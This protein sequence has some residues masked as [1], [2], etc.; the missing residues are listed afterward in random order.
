MTYP[1]SRLPGFR[2]LGV[3]ERREAVGRATGIEPSDVAAALDSGGLSV[4]TA[5]KIVENV[6]GTYAL[7][8]GVALNFLVDGVDRLVPM[9]IEEPSVVAAASNAAKMAREGG[10]FETHVDPSWMTCQ[11]QLYDVAD[12]PEGSARLVREKGALL[13]LA[14]RAV[15]DLV[16][17]GGGARE[18]EVRSLANGMLVVHVQ[19]DCLDAMGANMVNTI[20]EALGDRVAAVAGGRRGLRILSNL[21]DRRCVTVSCFV[22]ARALSSDDASGDAVVAAVVNASRFAESDPYRAATHNK[23]IMNGVDAVCVAT[24]NDW[25]AAEAGAHAYAARTG[26][27]APLAVW[28]EATLADG[29]FGLRGSLEM[30]LALGIVGGT[31]RA[32]PA[33]RLA[34]RLTGARTAAELA[35]LVAAAGLATNLAA[36]RALATV[37]IQKGHMTLHARAVAVAAGAAPGEVDRVADEIVEQHAITPEAARRA[38]ERMRCGA[39]R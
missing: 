31:L 2:K 38:I 27:Y 35:S 10:G 14:N 8:F 33:A 26:R 25:R 13:E 34:V 24:G 6:I 11:V 37:G 3:D 17:L 29:S 36:L 20:A 32:H 22:P 5:D 28:R 1:T 4:P 7:P 21:S 16:A 12:V 19:V 9:V 30:P 23:G 39:E 15:P 18:L